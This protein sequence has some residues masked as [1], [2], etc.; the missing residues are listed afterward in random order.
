MFPN[1][2]HRHDIRVMQASCRLGLAAKS[3][4][5]GRRQG[6]MERQHLERYVAAQGLLHGFVYDGHTTTSD[7]AHQVV[8]AKLLGNMATTLRVPTCSIS[9]GSS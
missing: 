2:E 9:F 3:L 1:T 4:Q 5:V 8:F 6:R 7:F